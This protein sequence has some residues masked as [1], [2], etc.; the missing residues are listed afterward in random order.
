MTGANFG[1]DIRKNKSKTCKRTVK[2]GEKYVNTS[3][4]DYHNNY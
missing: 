1:I 3:A 4:N 2:G